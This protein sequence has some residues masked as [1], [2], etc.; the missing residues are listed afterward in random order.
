MTAVRVALVL[1]YERGEEQ[2][3]TEVVSELFT[4]LGSGLQTADLSATRG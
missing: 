2:P 3:L 1:W 4:I